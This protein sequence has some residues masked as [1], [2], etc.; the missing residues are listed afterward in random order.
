V[1][2]YTRQT[3]VL[4]LTVLIATAAA[5][6]SN[7]RRG[8]IIIQGAGDVSLRKP[9][10]WETFIRLAGGPQ[11]NFVFVPTADGAVDLENLSLEE[12]PFSRLNHVTVLHTRCR[13][14]ADSEAFVAPL[15]K[16]TGVWFGSG[17]QFRLI[18]S[19]LH[20]RFQRELKL[21]L[22][23][24]GVIGG[25]S[26]GGMVL[27][28]QLVH[29]GILDQRVLVTKGYEEG[30]GLIGNSVIDQRVG[31]RRKEAD[32]S[33]VVEVHPE[34]VGLG[35]DESTSILVRGDI[36]EVIGPGR[37]TISDNRDHAGKKYYFLNTGDR[38]NL[39]TRHK[40][41]PATEFR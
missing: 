30:F 41:R 20:T 16:A 13:S 40:L 15:R 38:F 21:L 9:E 2:S 26:A 37:L 3:G 36:L 6:Q 31:A 25:W 4:I 33:E 28:S 19:Y 11:A 22:R 35:L 18:D 10:V 1:N 29:S 8:S 32:L 7:R 5:G 23:R 39:R 27:A 17:R 12:F 34:L 24:G 14:E